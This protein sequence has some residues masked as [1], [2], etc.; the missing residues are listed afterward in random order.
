MY[1]SLA[2]PAVLIPIQAAETLP[3]PTLK[4]IQI[5]FT[6]FTTFSLIKR[7]KKKK[8]AYHAVNICLFI[9]TVDGDESGFFVV[10]AHHSRMEVH[11]VSVIVVVT[12]VVVLP[13][14]RVCSTIR[15]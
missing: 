13:P 10:T 4:K 5:Y 11:Y 7:V 12:D 3:V 6:L 15:S 1:C 14:A 8:Q 9:F 2:M